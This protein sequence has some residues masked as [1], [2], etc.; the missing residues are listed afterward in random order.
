MNLMIDKGK[1]SDKTLK[2]QLMNLFK[3]ILIPRKILTISLMF[4]FSSFPS[5]DFIIPE[6]PYGQELVINIRT[7]WGDKHYV[8]LTGI[9]IFSDKGDSIIVKKVFCFNFPDLFC[10]CLHLDFGLAVLSY[11]K[12]TNLQNQKNCSNTRRHFFM[13]ILFFLYCFNYCAVQNRLVCLLYIF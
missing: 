10:H 13:F 9:D 3:I 4:H 7:T 1:K 8:G 12:E 6:L 2:A 5:D 11:F